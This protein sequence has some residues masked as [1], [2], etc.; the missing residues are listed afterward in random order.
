VFHHPEFTVSEL[1][2]LG[3]FPAIEALANISDFQSK[4]L[5]CFLQEDVHLLGSCG[6]H[7]T[8]QSN[9]PKTKPSSGHNPVFTFISEQ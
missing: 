6:V 3:G 8:R 4:P 2:A 9:S 5:L 7:H 1:G